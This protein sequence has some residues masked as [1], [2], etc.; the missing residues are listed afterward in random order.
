MTD[1]VIDMIDA[2]L[3]DWDTSGD[4]MRC[5]YDDT[6]P[7]V[8]ERDAQRPPTGGVDVSRWAEAG[9]ITDVPESMDLP[10]YTERRAA[11]Q[12][13]RDELWYQMLMYGN[14]YVERA[15]D[16]RLIRIL[17]PEEIDDMRV[18]EGLQP[19]LLGI[20]TIPQA[21]RYE[22]SVGP[23]RLGRADMDSDNH[24]TV[25]TERTGYKVDFVILDEATASQP[26]QET[27]RER[28]L[29]ARQHRHTGPQQN[30]HRHRGL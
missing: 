18:R 30:R 24:V 26:E 9:W 25:R 8:E 28:A 3:L 1:H 5:S 22:V 15:P 29:K 21:G 7:P 12:Q 13:V 4:A 11:E 10:R 20:V 14:V 16:G 6:L 23:F 17:P 2:A 19:D 27:T